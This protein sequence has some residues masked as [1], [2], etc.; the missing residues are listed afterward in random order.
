MKNEENSKKK[1]EEETERV[2]KR[3]FVWVE[4][5]EAEKVKEWNSKSE[6]ETEREGERERQVSS[7]QRR[8]YYFHDGKPIDDMRQ[9]R[10]GEEA[11]ATAAFLQRREGDRRECG[12][13]AT[14]NDNVNYTT[15]S[16]W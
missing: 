12:P 15:P 3:W 1:L 2:I 16:H 6:R 9:L 7:N 8:P 11:V 14:G 10:I 13:F 4:E 5:R